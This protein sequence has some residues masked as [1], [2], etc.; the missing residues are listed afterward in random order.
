MDGKGTVVGAGA[1]AGAGVEGAGAGAGS[2][3][4]TWVTEDEGSV[5]TVYIVVDGSLLEAEFCPFANKTDDPEEDKDEGEDAAAPTTG[6]DVEVDVGGE[7]FEVSMEDFPLVSKRR[8]QL[9]KT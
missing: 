5:A 9:P 1:G 2:G 8:S 6:V 7:E 3:V 4:A